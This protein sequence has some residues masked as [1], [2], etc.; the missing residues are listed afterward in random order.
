M[1][2][3]LYVGLAFGLLISCVNFYLSHVR[4]PL[5]IA[6]GRTPE[7]YKYESGLPLIGSFAIVVCLLLLQPPAWVVIVGVVGTIIDTGGIL[8]LLV[9]AVVHRKDLAKRPKQTFPSRKR[10]K[11]KGAGKPRDVA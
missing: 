8:W 4:Y 7:E 11:R 9:F 5:W 10:R 1:Q 3:I 2:A 6:S